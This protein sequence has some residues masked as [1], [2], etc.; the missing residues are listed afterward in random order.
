M[1]LIC[2]LLIAHWNPKAETAYSNNNNN[3]L[4]LNG[5]QPMGVP[6]LDGG[7]R[8]IG[9]CTGV[10]SSHNDDP[11][12]KMHS[13]CKAIEKDS[14]ICGFLAVSSCMH[15]CMYVYVYLCMLYS[16]CQRQAPLLW[17]LFQYQVAW[18]I[19]DI[20]KIVMVIWWY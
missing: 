6:V 14:C 18:D 17:E 13:K 10:E 3:N 19:V 16:Q 15:M 20:N 1:S 5:T 4:P 12:C 2:K 11:D 7:R 9:R 8:C